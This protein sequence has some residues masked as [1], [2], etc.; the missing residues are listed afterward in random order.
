MIAGQSTWVVVGAFFLIGLGLAFTPCV[1]PMIPILS[2]II[3]GHGQ[4]ITTRKA[5][6]LSLVY[7]LAMALTYTVAGVFA[8]L[9]GENLQAMLQNPVA[10]SIFAAGLCRPG[11]LDVR[12]L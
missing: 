7:V 10:I 3:T 9:A 12:L 2:G 1:F 8:A 4:S 11:L 5:F 6:M